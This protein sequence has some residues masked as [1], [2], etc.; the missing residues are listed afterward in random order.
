MK[1]GDAHVSKFDRSS[2]KILGTV[3]E[4]IKAPEWNWYNNVVG[5]NKCHVLDTFWQ[6]ETGGHMIVNLPYI[7]K[8]KPGSSMQPVPGVKV[9][10]LDINTNEKL[11]ANDVQGKLCFEP[12]WPGQARGVWGDKERFLEVYFKSTPGQ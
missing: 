6:T 4:T 7:K 11:T 8:N 3:G 10:I 2:I 12:G 9:A 5:E 1:Q